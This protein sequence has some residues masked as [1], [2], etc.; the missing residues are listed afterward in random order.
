M[1]NLKVYLP[2]AMPDNFFTRNEL[3]SMGLVPINPDE[4]DALVDFR[5]QKRVYKL[6]NIEKTRQPKMHKKSF[7]LIVRDNTVEDIL[8]KRRRRKNAFM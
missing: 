7:S 6:Y 8:E 3:N 2:N 4:P 5:Q 1:E